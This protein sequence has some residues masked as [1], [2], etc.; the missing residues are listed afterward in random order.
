MLVFSAVS[1]A[2][3]STAVYTLLWVLDHVTSTRTHNDWLL[4]LLPVAGFAIG[5]AY[6]GSEPSV[7][8]GSATVAQSRRDGTKGIPLTLAWYSYASTW[9][10]HLFGGSGGRIAS[11]MQISAALT[12]AAARRLRCTLRE[13]QMLLASATSAVFATVLGTPLAGMVFAVE[14]PGRRGPGYRALVPSAIGAFVAQA[15]VGGFGYRHATH[16]AIRLSASVFNAG[17]LIIA[18]VVFGL[19]AALYVRLRDAIAWLCVRMD[20]PALATA[21]GGIWIVL[22][23]LIFGRQ[24]LGLSLP[25]ANAALLGGSVAS[26]AWLLKIIVTAITAGSGF[27]AGEVTPM[28]VI[29]ATLGAAF[30]GPL[31]LDS[32]VLAAMG[33]VAVFAAA[34]KAPFA[35]AILGVELFGTGAAGALLLVCI[36]ARCVSGSKGIYPR[37]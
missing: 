6:Q 34:S 24:Y 7:Q 27:R 14:E 28:L 26:G 20:R 2:I 21:T 17:K 19:A 29:G 23:A 5:R 4:F 32:E 12:D 13:R 10:T 22:F 11:G 30:A 36:I 35:C 31:N 18:A 8:L 9:V 16:P 3:G 1:G 15:V 25:L 37:A 33:F